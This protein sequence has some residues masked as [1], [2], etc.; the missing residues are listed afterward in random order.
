MR[1]GDAQH[2][3][4]QLDHG[5][6]QCMQR[7]LQGRGWCQWS[8]QHPACPPARGTVGINPAYGAQLLCTTPR[9]RLFSAWV[10]VMATWKGHRSFGG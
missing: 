8:C 4:A 10:S 6:S 7:S 3:Q 2:K 5:A 9:K 1:S